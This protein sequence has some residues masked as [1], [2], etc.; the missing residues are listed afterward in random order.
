MHKN[1]DCDPPSGFILC[2]LVEY[3]TFL[4]RL[5]TFYLFL[6]NGHKG[7]EER[8]RVRK[9]WHSCGVIKVP[10]K[11]HFTVI[12]SHHLMKVVVVDCISSRY[13]FQ[14]WKHFNA[15]LVGK[16]GTL[17]GLPNSVLENWNWI[18]VKFY[19]EASF[20]LFTHG[21]SVSPSILVQCN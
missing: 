4:S 13:S 9:W 20:N 3:Y 8:H 10:W 15:L 21:G 14:P 6:F 18:I 7:R 16:Q 5:R 2:F 19:C 17:L 12:M 1:T 11:K